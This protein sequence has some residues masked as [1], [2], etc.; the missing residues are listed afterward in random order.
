M[1]GLM[2]IEPS[3]YSDDRGYFMESFNQR[4]FEEATGLKTQF[5]QDNES[6]SNRGVLRGLH[7]QV[8]PKGQDKL[9]RV[10]KGRVIDVVVDLRK[11]SPTYG[12]HEKVLLSE[13][14]K[15]QL[16]VPIGFAHGFLV[17]EDH[18]V[19][20]YKCSAFYDKSSERVLRWDDPD[21][22]IEWDF[23]DPILSEK[24]GNAELTLSVFD[25]PFA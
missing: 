12:K 20:S 18:T 7:F 15:R 17:L 2:V 22:G 23:S 10:V 9:V 11:G 4:R 8:P 14:N 16:Y 3:V 13:E 24:D 25:S 19:F 1:N 21:I 5:V 6:M